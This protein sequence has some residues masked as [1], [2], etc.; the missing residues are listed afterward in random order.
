[1]KVQCCV[2]KKVRKGKHWVAV[3]ELQITEHVSH[4]YCPAC[5]AQAFAE[6]HELLYAGRLVSGRA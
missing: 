4:G 3:P 5:A 2:C 1:M 6:I